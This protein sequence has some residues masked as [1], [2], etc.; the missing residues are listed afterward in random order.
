MKLKEINR[1]GTK[2]AKI[3]NGFLRALHL[4]AVQKAMYA[5][6]I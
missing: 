2:N 1:E 5:N 6:A 3:F 4:F